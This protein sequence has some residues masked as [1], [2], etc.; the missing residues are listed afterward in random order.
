MQWGQIKTLFILSF[1][2][3]NI[4]LLVQLL[5]KQ[6]DAD[7][8]ILERSEST[9]EEQ[10][11]EDQITIAELPEEQAKEPYI[12]VKEKVFVEEDF[13][14]NDGITNQRTVIVDKTLVVSVFKKPV[15]LPSDASED[16]IED[17]VK[18]SFA[19]PE[20]YVYWDWNKEANVLIF[21]QVEI[22]RPVYFNQNG[23]IVVYLN[24][25]NEME[26]YTQ[27]MLDEADARQDKSSLIKPITA[28]E[29]LYNANELR[30]GEEI[31]K[32]DIG[33]HTRA[34]KPSGVQVFVPAWKVTVND[35]RNYFVNAIE[36]WV[37]S[38]DEINFME[39]VF[40]HNIEMIE[41]IV[42]HK[43]VRKKTLEILK[44]KLSEIDRGD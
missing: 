18:K 32:V 42:D 29:I 30:T 3:L 8:D 12:S 23:M 26:F 35:E 41:S 22:D 37:F 16:S 5:E 6:E 38:N 40:S 36:G 25:D 14:K 24:D 15:K 19:F 10:L 34:P 28:V 4:Y 44:E 43:E 20:D 13:H 2:I 17:F 31:T 21:F 7:K 9:I 33:F 27:T 39:T 11:K 1:L